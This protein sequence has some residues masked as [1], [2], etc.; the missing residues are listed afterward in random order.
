ME[1]VVF[2]LNSVCCNLGCY[3]VYGTNSLWPLKFFF[4]AL[5]WSS[6]LNINSN[7]ILIQMNGGTFLLELVGMKIRRTLLFGIVLMRPLNFDFGPPTGDKH[8]PELVNDSFFPPGSLSLSVQYS[9]VESWKLSTCHIICLF[10]INFLCW[11]LGQVSILVERTIS[12]WIF[13]AWSL[14]IY[15]KKMQIMYYVVIDWGKYLNALSCL[16]KC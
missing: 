12:S 4:I 9:F 1:L 10:H 3:L 16:K 6:S 7:H 14:F 11:I 8:W 15:I 2:Y 13:V 5:F